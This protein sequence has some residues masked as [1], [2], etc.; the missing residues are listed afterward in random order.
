M[1]ER[2]SATANGFY[3]QWKP[4]HLASHYRLDVG[5]DPT[6][7][8]ERQFETCYTR[9]TTYAAGY[10]NEPRTGACPRRVAL[11]PTG[12]SSR[13]TTRESPINGVMSEVR[14]LQYSPGW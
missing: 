11:P 10:V 9:Q 7:S 5:T 6:F 13:W 12:V 4:M 8:D 2:S 14:M 1:T 3:F